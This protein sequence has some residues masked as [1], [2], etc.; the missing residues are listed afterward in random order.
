M[1]HFT[2]LTRL[3]N[4]PH[5]AGFDLGS[6]NVFSAKCGELLPV[7]WDLGIPGCTYDINLQYF[8]RTRPVQTA[9]VGST[10]QGNQFMQNLGAGLGLAQGFGLSSLFNQGSSA[11]T[12]LVGGDIGRTFLSWANGSLHIHAQTLP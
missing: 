5:R 2:G 1:A 10:N 11:G 9:G 4:H 6:K 7:F 12:S 3:Q 8:T